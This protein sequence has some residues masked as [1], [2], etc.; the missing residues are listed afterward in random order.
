MSLLAWYPLIKDGKNQGLNGTNLTLRGSVPFSAGKLGNAATFSQNAA[1]SYHK[2]GGFKLE[3]KF[4]WACWVKVASTEST[5]AQFILS[6]GRDVG[7]IGINL[8]CNKD[9]T[10]WVSSTAGNITIG[11]PALDTWHHVVITVNSEDKIRTY[12]DGVESG[13]AINF[14]TLD[15]A[16]SQDAF[17]I[18]KMSHAYTGSTTYFPFCGQVQDVRI[19]DHVLSKKEI[20][21]LAK[22]LCIHIPLNWG[23]NPNMIKQSYTFMNKNTGA[24]NQWTNS[25]ITY[26]TNSVIE[27]NT[28]P[29]KWVLKKGITNSKESNVGGAGPFYGIATKGLA[30]TDLTENEYYTY[31]FW[32][33]SDS[34]IPSGL[35]AGAVV[36]GQ[37]LVSYTGFGALTS[38]W[39]LHTVTFKFT[40]TTSLTNCFYVTVPASSTVDFEVCGMKLEKGQKATPYI[41]HVEETAYTAHG[42]SNM[43]KEDLSG[44]KKTT[45]I[46]SSPINGGV[47]PKGTSCTYF[48]GTDDGVQIDE[49]AMPKIISDKFTMS[50]WIKPDGEAGARSV[51]FGSNGNTA[52]TLNIEK[53]ASN[54]LRFYWNGNPDYNNTSFTIADDSWQH[55]AI[56]RESATSTKF[57]KNGTLVNTYTTNCAVQSTGS[58]NYYIGRDNRTGATCYKGYMSDFRFYASALSAN[59]IKELY[60]ISAH[61][62][63]SGNMYCTSFVEQ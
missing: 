3:D 19:Y 4:S 16:Q 21:E 46:L 33:K 37:T 45:T 58:T 39:R 42:Y 23:G 49:S 38:T 25:G 51:Y 61:I 26:P 62:D 17:V 15:Y 41:P 31:S 63:K 7:S 18:G 14:A 10:L 8:R 12:L 48:D 35:G 11:K 5:T 32:A 40:K 30:T 53:N 54:Q 9:G 47:S 24:N 6:E 13:T 28:A 60:N 50:F 34:G 1:N 22:G 44:T 20:K 43:F 27:D 29:C 56:V 57:Y 55:I 59:D 2:A 36:E 52:Y